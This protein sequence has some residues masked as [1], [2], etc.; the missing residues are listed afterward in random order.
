MLCSNCSEVVRPVVA[1]DIDGTLANYHRHLC[2]F[3]KDWLNHYNV[4]DSYDGSVPYRDWFTEAFGVD[5]TT[6]RAIKLAYRQG[7]M[8]RLMPAYSEAALFVNSLSH[9]HDAEVWI[10]TTRPHDRFD[11]V[12]PDTRNWLDRHGIHYD[13]LLYHGNKMEELANRVDPARV[14]AVLDDQYGVLAE[15]GL[16]FTESIPILRKTPYNKKAPW[17]GASVETLAGARGMISGLIER[18]KKE[19]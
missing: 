5:V 10:T 7:G 9:Y 17:T 16:L 3:A 19:N 8:K 4:I 15:A 13:G 14:V 2:E 6:F 1:I 18:W 12:D 11:R